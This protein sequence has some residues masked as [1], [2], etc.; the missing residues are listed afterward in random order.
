MAEFQVKS[1]DDTE[2]K[3]TQEIEAELLKEHEEPEVAAETTEVLVNAD[4]NEVTVNSLKTETTETETPVA[5]TT[6]ATEEEVSENINDN[7]VLSYINEKYNREVNS[8][9]ELFTTEEKDVDLPEDVAAFL[10]YKKDTG[11][12][13]NDYVKLNKNYEDS[14]PDEI[15]AEYYRQTK[16][17][18]DEEDIQFELENNFGYDPD[19]D[20]EKEGKK[21]TIAKKQELSKAK[22]YFENLKKEYLVPV[23]SAGAGLSENDQKGFEAY[24]KLAEESKAQQE[25]TQKRRE[26]FTEKTNELF[27]GDFKGFDFALG[28]KDVVYKPS[29]TEQLKKN[30]STLESFIDTHINKDG[31]VKDVGAY[32][33]SL[34]VALNPDGFARFFYEQGK[35]DAIDNV[36]KE[37]KNIDMGSVRTAPESV[38]KGGFKVTNMSN[39]KFGNRLVIRS[40]K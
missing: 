39:E 6:E 21:R 25:H 19:Y 16:T 12:G 17:H 9:D 13:L 27:T 36:T 23:E 1:L 14:N 7:S 3:S 15:L 38:S 34:A 32:H 29:N 26:Y 2:Q 40:S 28:D 37:T 10:K 24:K 18:L 20:D 35:A 31:Y 30:Q 5:T 22:E 33:R 4:T 11:R 8:I